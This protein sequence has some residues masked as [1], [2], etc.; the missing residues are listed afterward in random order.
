MTLPQSVHV[1][2][3][4]NDCAIDRGGDASVREI[5]LGLIESRRAWRAWSFAEPNC[6]GSRRLDPA[7]IDGLFRCVN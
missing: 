4:G 7:P 1:H 2:A 3:A 5:D 6:A